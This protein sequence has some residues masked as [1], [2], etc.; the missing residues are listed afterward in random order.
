M[1]KLKRAE[2]ICICSWYGE[3]YSPEKPVMVVVS[4]IR[5]MTAI[6]LTNCLP[7]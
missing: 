2:W 6:C 5:L 1:Q 4:G 7:R 3:G